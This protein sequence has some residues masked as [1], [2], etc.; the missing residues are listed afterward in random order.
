MTDRRR[1]PLPSKQQLAAFIRES[2]VP[3][4]KREIA[5]A[6]QIAAEDRPA[7]RQLLKELEEDGTVARGR[8]RRLARPEALAEIA[9]VEVSDIDPDGEVICRPVNWTGEGPLPRIILAP[10][11][12]GAAGIGDRV[13]ARLK[14]VGAA[15]YEGVAIRKIG[16]APDRVLGVFEAPNRLR[17]T[18]RRD[19]ASY[20]IAP[21]QAGGARDGDLVL[22]QVVRAARFGPQDAKVLEVLGE[23]S[24]P[25]A[26][27]LIAIATHDIPVEFSPAALAQAAAARPVPLGRRSDLRAV[28]LVTIDGEDARDFDDAVWAEPDGDPANPGGWHILVAIAD[29]A[30]YVRDGDALDKAAR[31][32]GNSVYFPDRV[33]PMLPEAL[34]NDLCSL[35]PQEDR[36]CLVAEMWIDAEGGKRRHRFLRALMRSAARLSYTQAQATQDRGGDAITAPLYGAFRALDTARRRRGTLDL[37]L[38]ERKVVLNPDGTVREIGQRERL[39][40]HRLI[41]E[42]MILANVAAA[43]TLERHRTACMYR[44][45]D[46]PAEEKVEAYR[47]F[48]AT[49][50]LKLAKGQVLKPGHFARIVRQAAGSP[51]EA[52]VNELTLRTQAQA[53]YS[54]ENIGHFGLAL[55]KYAHFTSPIR[56]YSD[57]LVHRALIRA[58]D[59][60]EGGLPDVAPEDFA[61]LGQHI[62]VTE[63]RA[64][65]AERDAV[66]RFVALFLAERRG[67]R[68]EGRITGVTRFGLFVRL[69]GVGADGFVP[70]RTL[71]D[72][73][74]HHDAD[75]HELVGKR[76]RLCFALGDRVAVTLAE[77]DATTGSLLLTLETGA[78]RRP[79]PPRKSRR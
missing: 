19:R 5:R 75:R 43:E 12:I 73:F 2:A 20:R 32:R 44:V 33:V 9:I 69:D 54:P 7:L 10:E 8:S 57:L 38:P 28:P 30:W 23:A 59:L 1:A 35:R 29:V 53:V 67:E 24:S 46:Q 62:S 21:D 70:I 40:S 77:A 15:E 11:K 58:L 13:L 34:S 79:A 49:L 3:V 76:S 55:P 14:R 4:G 56:R 18:D 65:M 60:G 74:Y 26:I 31:L 63:R 41:E 61:R 51:H 36:A 48:L 22:C 72:D 47:S 16:A 64:A 25:R 50:G 52:L 68:F 17:P 71:P 42:F 45:H 27:S 39:D 6:F 78:A 66:D 37:D